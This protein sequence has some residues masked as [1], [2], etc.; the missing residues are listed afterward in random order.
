MLAYVLRIVVGVSHSVPNATLAADLRPKCMGSLEVSM[1]SFGRLDGTTNVGER[2]V[3][4]I[5]LE[6]CGCVEAS[7]SVILN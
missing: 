5:V 2:I 1:E 4:L 7:S 6:L 3:T